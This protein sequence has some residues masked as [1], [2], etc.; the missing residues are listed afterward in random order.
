MVKHPHPTPPPKKKQQTKSTHFK[1][2]S[3]FHKQEERRWEI[4]TSIE[5]DYKEEAVMLQSFVQYSNTSLKRNLLYDLV[6][7][8]SKK[9]KLGSKFIIKLSDE[10]D[11]FRL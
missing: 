4:D 3:L 7:K 9:K 6:Q 8:N 11:N 2:Y 5:I 1:T 10:Y